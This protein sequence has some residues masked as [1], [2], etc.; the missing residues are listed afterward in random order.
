M[1]GM[2]ASTNGD[3]NVDRIPP[4]DSRKP[5]P[6]EPWRYVCPECGCQVTKGQASLWFKC[7]GCSETWEYKEL[8]DQKHGCKVKEV[9]TK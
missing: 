5:D 7:W 8:W 9:Q 1:T 2:T 3:G 6:D 4:I